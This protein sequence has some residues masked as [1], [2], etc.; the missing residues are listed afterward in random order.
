MKAEAD[1]DRIEQ[2]VRALLHRNRLRVTTPCLAVLKLLARAEAPLS[3]TEVLDQLGKLECD[4]ATIYRNLVKLTEVGITRVASRID[5]V[6]RYA[7]AMPGSKEHSHPH[8][9][10][11]ECKEI[12]CLSA[13]IRA[14]LEVEESW[15]ESIRSAVCDLRG[16]CPA[17]LQNKAVP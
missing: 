4:P 6:D 10:C 17:C 16:L 15:R 5:G 12:T 9:Y 14:C 11:T 13:D 7:L 8:F 2:E 1:I 3:H